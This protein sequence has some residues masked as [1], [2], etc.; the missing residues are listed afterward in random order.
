MQKKISILDDLLNWMNTI[1]FGGYGPYY[2][3]GWLPG[4]WTIW[5]VFLVRP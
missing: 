3:M 2:G 5:R 1:D 4:L